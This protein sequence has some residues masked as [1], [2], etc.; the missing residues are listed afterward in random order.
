MS[1]LFELKRKLAEFLF[2]VSLAEGYGID[3]KKKRVW[4]HIKG[5]GVIG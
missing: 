4:I 2:D 3:Y 5:I 1:R